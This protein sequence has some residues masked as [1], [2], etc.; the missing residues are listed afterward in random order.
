MKF[1]KFIPAVLI[2][3]IILFSAACKKEKDDPIIP[4]EEEL[5]TSLYLTL[6]D[7]LSNDTIELSFVDLDG[8]GGDPPIV[9]TENLNSNTSYQGYL[10]ILNESSTPPINI[11]VEVEEEAE[12]HQV[13]YESVGGLDLVSMYQ[14]EDANGNP[15]GINM[16]FVTSSSSNGSLIITLR[17]EPDKFAEGVSEGDIAN[18]GGETDIQVTFDIEIQ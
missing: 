10:F 5:I 17:H 8:D 13:F 12:E 4:N 2:L 1:N 18:A 14:D 9:N 16:G 15:L 3:A 6:I 11:S 7:S